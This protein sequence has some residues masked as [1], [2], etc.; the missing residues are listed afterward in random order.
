MSGRYLAMEVIVRLD[1]GVEREDVEQAILDAVGCDGT[2]PDCRMQN[3]ASTTGTFDE[4][5]QWLDPDAPELQH[6]TITERCGQ[7]G[8]CVAVLDDG[9]PMPR[10]RDRCEHL[11]EAMGPRESEAM[12]AIRIV[13][14]DSSVWTFNFTEMLF[15]RCP[16]VEGGDHPMVKYEGEWQSFAR[17]EETDAVHWDDRVRMTVFGHDIAGPGSD[18]ITTTYQPAAQQVAL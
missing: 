14:T 12:S 17:I 15:L 11:L 2:E 16:R 10:E 7:C 3:L 8:F 1:D 9:T 6:A 4:C 13:V 18:W 5:C